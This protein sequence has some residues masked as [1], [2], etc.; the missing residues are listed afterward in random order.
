MTPLQLCLFETH[1]S[2]SM[3]IERLGRG[4]RGV[5]RPVEVLGE[6]RRGERRRLPRRVVFATQV[7]VNKK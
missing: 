4:Q 7:K 2:L 5:G 6:E 3:N 1:L